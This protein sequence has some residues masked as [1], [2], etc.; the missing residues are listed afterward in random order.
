MNRNEKGFGLVEAVL[1][2]FLLGL[3]SFVGWY[4]YRV[5]NETVTIYNNSAQ[6]TNTQTVTPIK[7]PSDWQ[8]FISK[9]KS[10]KFAY[11]KTWGTLSDVDSSNKARI[12]TITKAK[13]FLFYWKTGFATNTWYTWNSNSNSLESA[14]DTNPPVNPTSGYLKPIKLGS[15]SPATPI[16]NVGGLNVYEIHGNGAMNCGG[17]DFIFQTKGY[18]VDIPAFVCTKGGEFTAESQDAQYYDIYSDAF[19]TFYKYI[20]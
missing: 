9:D 2:V 8:Q 5:K 16:S 3:F 15:S 14:I 17:I 6:T 20:Q 13:D 19:K 11:P 4:V 1:I 18:V 10:V 7:I 12:I